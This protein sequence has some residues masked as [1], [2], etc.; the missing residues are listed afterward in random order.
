MQ[1]SDVINIIQGGNPHS[2]AI[3]VVMSQIMVELGVE[4]CPYCGNHS[5][6]IFETILGKH[7]RCPDCFCM[8][9]VDMAQIKEEAIKRVEAIIASGEE[10]GMCCR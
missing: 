8:W 3:M 9:D 7:Y 10:T 6:Q 5:P 4:N 1:K 2:K